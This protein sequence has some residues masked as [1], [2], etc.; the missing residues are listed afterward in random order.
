MVEAGRSSKGTAAVAGSARKRQRRQVG[1]RGKGVRE[2]ELICYAY[3]W[4]GGIRVCSCHSSH[5]SK[6]DSMVEIYSNAV[7]CN[8]F[9]KI[10]FMIL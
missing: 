4:G 10:L 6:A 5:Q 2:W 8:T 7:Y 9:Q 1:F 3:V